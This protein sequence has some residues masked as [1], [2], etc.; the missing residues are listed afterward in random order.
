VPAW[1]DLLDAPESR[2]LP[3]LGGRRV[4]DRNRAWRIAGD[5]PAEFGWYSFE[6]SGRIATLLEPAEPEAGWEGY[7]NTARGYLVGNRFIPE[8]ARVEPDPDK[9]IEQTVPV[10]LVEPGLDRFAPVEICFDPVH[11]PIYVQ[12]LFDLGPEDAV[13]RAFIDK[14]PDVHDV[15]GVPPAL[16]LAFRFASRQRQLLEERRAEVER[17]RQEEE[18]REAA[19]RNMG[20]GLGRRTLAATDFPAAARA[21]LR[22]GGAEF[23]D[24]RPG[25]RHNEMI[26]QYRFENRRLECVCDKATLRIIDSGI[27]L[28]DHRTGEKGDTRF[29]LET[30]PGVVRQALDEGRL[31]VYRH[32]D[33]DADDW[34]D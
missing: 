8:K 1:E 32:V 4:Y 28:T 14:R 25:Y 29:T 33:G 3:W 16:D 19:R 11:R 13:R 2:V 15:P 26:V 17:R 23:L 6:L 12:Q 24:A 10:F 22:V 7:I 20:T 34:N 30:L 9:L 5:L 18:R 27:C 21:A 31:V